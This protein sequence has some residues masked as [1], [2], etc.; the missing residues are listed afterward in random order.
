MHQGAALCGDRD[1]AGHRV[2]LADITAA[3]V[4]RAARVAVPIHEKSLYDRHE[5]PRMQRPGAPPF[6]VESDGAQ[7]IIDFARDPSATRLPLG[8]MRPEKLCKVLAK[9]GFENWA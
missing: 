6:Q 5:K 8:I 9:T 3:R 1:V 2:G 7:T 4:D